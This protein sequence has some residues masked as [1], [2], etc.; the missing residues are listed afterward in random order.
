[1]TDC[2]AKLPPLSDVVFRRLF[3]DEGQDALLLHLL[4]ALLAWP[5]PL[6]TI[7]QIPSHRTGEEADD[8][9]PVLD[10]V[11]RDGRGRQQNVEVQLDPKAAFRERTLFYWAR[12][13]TGQLRRGM[14]YK[15]LR[16]TA[17]ISIID[18]NL[19]DK[20]KR[21]KAEQGAELKAQQT[22]PSATSPTA[23]A[24]P[25]VPADPAPLGWHPIYELRRRSDGH[26]LTNHLELHYIEVP[27]FKAAV[28]T[29]QDATDPE[30]EWGYTSCVTATASPP[31]TPP[32]LGPTSRGPRRSFA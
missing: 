11:G 27:T 31:R 1:M 22:L 30:K 15:E 3:D 9:E 8:K 18:W 23:P 28:A 24:G 25:G 20:E 17:C 14:P 2:H 21:E 12:L 16:P 32:S 19:R 5:E 7:T 4:N 13:Y 10:V 26:L 6:M 29:L